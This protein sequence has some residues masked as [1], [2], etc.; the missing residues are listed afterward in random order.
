MVKAVGYLVSDRPS[1]SAMSGG[2]LM[3]PRTSLP[4]FTPEQIVWSRSQYAHNK[5]GEKIDH[6]TKR[7]PFIIS[8][9]AH[10]VIL[11]TVT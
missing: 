1:Y 11:D 10:K 8:R 4:L 7:V 9:Q 6:N 2:P 5:V 3:D